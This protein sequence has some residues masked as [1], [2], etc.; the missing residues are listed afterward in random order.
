MNMTRV[1]LSEILRW[2]E[3]CVKYIKIKKKL[4]KEMWLMECAYFM[5]A[6]NINSVGLVLP[7]FLDENQSGTMIFNTHFGAQNP[8]S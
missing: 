6:L 1:A 8:I 4:L 7:L 5:E 3:G 2:E